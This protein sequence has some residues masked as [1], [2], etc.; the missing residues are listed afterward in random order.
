MI[1]IDGIWKR[2]TTLGIFLVGW[3]TSP[4]S[5][6]AIWFVLSLVYILYVVAASWQDYVKDKS[7]RDQYIKR[8][9][10]D[11]D[12]QQGHGGGD[13]GQP[14]VRGSGGRPDYD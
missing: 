1:S 11:Y 4:V 6:A 9:S 7:K 2:L 8:R 10:V 5:L 13:Y 3:Q 14:Y 12:E